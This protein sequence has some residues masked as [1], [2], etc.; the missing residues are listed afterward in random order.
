M[1][2]EKHIKT[3]SSCF[4]KNFISPVTITVKRDKTVKPALHSK[5]SNKF[6]DHRKG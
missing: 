2:D 3:P 6:F 4:D 1:L 5:N